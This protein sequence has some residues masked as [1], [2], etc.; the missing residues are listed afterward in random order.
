MTNR[1]RRRAT[2]LTIDFAIAAWPLSLS[3][4]VSAMELGRLFYYPAE[5]ELLNHTRDPGGHCLAMKG[6]LMRG[7]KNLQIWIA[8][9]KEWTKRTNRG[10][11]RI[12]ETVDSNGRVTFWINDDE[13][14]SVK[15]GQTFD[16]ANRE[17]RDAFDA[18]LRACPEQ[19]LTRLH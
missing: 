6:V 7:G 15:P 19:Q 14:A 8:K 10:A 5:R 1:S 3:M 2:F 17:T 12:E 16:L 11:V 13:S 4:S 9:D 18:R